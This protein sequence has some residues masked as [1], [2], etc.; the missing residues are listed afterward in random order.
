LVPLLEKVERNTKLQ[1]ESLQRVLEIM[2]QLQKYLD[3]NKGLTKKRLDDH[4]KEI[5]RIGV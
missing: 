4:L 2:V 3:P 5:R 1:N